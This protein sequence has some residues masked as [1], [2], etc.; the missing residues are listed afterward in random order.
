MYSANMGFHLGHFLSFN[1]GNEQAGIESNRHVF[2]R[3]QDFNLGD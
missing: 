1:L 3:E 2:F